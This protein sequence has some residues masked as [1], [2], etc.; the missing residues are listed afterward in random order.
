[1][2]RH[3]KIRARHSPYYIPR[4]EACKRVGLPSVRHNYEGLTGLASFPVVFPP[5]SSTGNIVA[6]R[7]HSLP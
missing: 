5:G 6:T 7:S 2:I 1:M 3:G 4:R